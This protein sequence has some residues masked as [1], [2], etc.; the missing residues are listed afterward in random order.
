[1]TKS[2]F[3]SDDLLEFEKKVIA[4]IRSYWLDHGDEALQKSADML[5][6]LTARTKVEQRAPLQLVVVSGWMSQQFGFRIKR[7][8]LQRLNPGYKIEIRRT[9][10]PDAPSGRVHGRRLGFEL[11]ALGDRSLHPFAFSVQDGSGRE[12]ALPGSSSESRFKLSHFVSA[13]VSSATSE[14]EPVGFVDDV[15]HLGVSAEDRDLTWLSAIVHRNPRE[16]MELVDSPQGHDLA[17]HVA[18]LYEGW[19][20]AARWGDRFALVAQGLAGPF[21]SDLRPVGVVATDVPPA[22]PTTVAMPVPRPQRSGNVVRFTPG[23]TVAR[24]PSADWVHLDFAV[25][26]NGGTVIADGAFVAYEAS[27]HPSLDVVSGQSDTVFGSRM[28]PEAALVEMRPIANEVVPEGILISGRND[29]NWFHWFIEYLPRVLMIEPGIDDDVPLLV[30]ARVPKTGIAALKSL[31]SR[32]IVELDAT[33]AY[34]VTR[35]HVVAPQM[36]ILDSTR[37]AWPE[38]LSVNIDSLLAVRSA[39]GLG[40]SVVDGGRKVFL[41]RKSG[42]RGMTNEADIAAIAEKHGLEVMDPGAMTWEEQRTLFSSAS[43][44]VG[45]SGAVMANYLLMTR[46]SRVLALT[47][48]ALE[49]FVLPAVIAAAAGVDFTYVTGQSSS[50]LGDHDHRIGWMHSDFHIPEE[51]FEAALLDE[52]AIVGPTF[53]V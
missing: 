30:T 46:G 27:A 47:S 5:I 50:E 32:R 19:P 3:L 13:A 4:P 25:V 16:I 7:R 40:D 26:Q 29:F 21:S 12:I 2:K 42:H 52:L 33:L 36:Q 38:G 45:A 28:H 24:I 22:V 18:R 51:A 41:Q 35:L 11:R 43:L 49:D 53:S 44:L 17:R 31:S 37:L 20:A 15:L 23:A 39:L 6:G 14:H 48:V 1:M 8:H 10:R 9:E 34:R